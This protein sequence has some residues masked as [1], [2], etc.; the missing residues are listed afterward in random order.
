MSLDDVVVEEPKICC[1]NARTT[2]QMVLRPNTKHGMKHQGN[3]NVSRP[4]MALSLS[5]KVSG[6]KMA[7]TQ[8]QLTREKTIQQLVGMSYSY[9]K[10]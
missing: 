1:A 9:F 2:T 4:V 7:L 3:E 5:V 10:P 6:Q 8:K